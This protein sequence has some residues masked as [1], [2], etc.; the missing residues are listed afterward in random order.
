MYIYRNMTDTIHYVVPVT[1]YIL[2]QANVKPS[3]HEKATTLS[4]RL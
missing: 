2:Y 4:Q 1:S 3:H